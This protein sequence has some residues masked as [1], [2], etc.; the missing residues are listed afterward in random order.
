MTRIIG[1]TAGSNLGKPAVVAGVGIL[2]ISV[3]AGLANFGAVEGLVIGGDATTT[4]HDILAS[5]TTFRLAIAA[6]V[7]V[8]VLD[9]IV[10]WALYA[11]FAL[12]GY[13]I[14]RS[15]SSPKPL[16]VLVAVAGAGYLVDSFGALLF[17]DYALSVGAVTFVGEF[18]LMLWLLLR[19]RTV[20]SPPLRGRT[21]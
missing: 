1:R 9:V 2:L 10:A 6:F 8:A 21:P 4:A 5:E 17:S 20:A 11:F 7:V 19:G 16:G 3:L 18:L 13:L 15:G 14:Y 12:V